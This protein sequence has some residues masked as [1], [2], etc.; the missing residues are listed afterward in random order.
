MHTRS[1]SFYL[2]LT[3]VVPVFGRSAQPAMVMFDIKTLR[4]RMMKGEEKKVAKG[5]IQRMNVDD[6][7]EEE[8]SLSF[9]G[10]VRH[11]SLVEL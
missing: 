6:E 11:V 8:K 9:E 2:S 4:R 3:L 1:H 7:K 5:E 10:G